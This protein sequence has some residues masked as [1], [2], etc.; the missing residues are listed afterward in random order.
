[1]ASNKNLYNFKSS[2]TGNV[3]THYLLTRG[4]ISR[5]TFLSRLIFVLII[6]LF[7]TLINIFY[8]KSNNTNYSIWAN[9]YFYILPCFL[10]LFI[11]IQ[12]AK[13]IHDINK[14]A[15]N[16]LIPLLNFYY[17]LLP[18]TNGNNDYG[19]DSS[20]QKNIKYF[21]QVD[22]FEASTSSNTKRTDLLKFISII[23]LLIFTFYFYKNESI[24]STIRETTEYTLPNIN[25]GLNV[26]NRDQLNIGFISVSALDKN[27]NSCLLNVFNNP[28]IK[29]I[30]KDNIEK[31]VKGMR[32]NRID[33]FLLSPDESRRIT[34]KFDRT[35]TFYI[36]SISSKAIFILPAENIDIVND[37]NN[38]LTDNSSLK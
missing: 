20:P 24:K 2:K 30:Q 8:W 10:L 9:F 26:K 4:R 36:K 28:S 13:R 19:I 18:G 32:E 25:L 29:Y 22:S 17:I 12:G 6:F 5:S 11:L 23:I 37:L 27:K 38:C 1:M 3:E 15:F 21:D 7:F 31:L 16:V 33:L 14:S 35:N 34:G